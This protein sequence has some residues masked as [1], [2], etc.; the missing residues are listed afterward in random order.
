MKK[1]AGASIVL[2]ICIFVFAGV[3]AVGRNDPISEYE[4]LQRSAAAVGESDDHVAYIGK[5]V[6]ITRSEIEAAKRVYLANGEDDKRAEQDAI[7][8][9][10]EF[11]ALYA[12]AEMNG[13]HATED[14]IEKYLSELKEMLKVAENADDMER[15][16]RTF[17]DEEAFW[18]YMRKVYI[19]RLPAQNY[20]AHLE[21]EFAKTCGLDMWSEEYTVAW[22]KEFELI[23]SVAVEK[24]AYRSAE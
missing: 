14:D 22:E 2:M 13:F 16:M 4:R 10:Q 11:N 6:V 17:G 24:Q 15:I 7:R 1:R 23:K 18:D 19:K 3:V 20:V 8:T 12:D 21:E 9:M 5:D